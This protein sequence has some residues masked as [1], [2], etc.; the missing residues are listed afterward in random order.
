MIEAVYGFANGYIDNDRSKKIK[1]GGVK[2]EKFFHR[3]G[4]CQKLWA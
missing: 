4:E 3:L 2:S 1:K